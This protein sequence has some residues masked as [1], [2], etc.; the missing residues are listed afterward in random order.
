MEV[1]TVYGDNWEGVYID[2]VLC[3]ESQRLP[4]MAALHAVL[5]MGVS[6]P[7]WG[8]PDVKLNEI[9]LFTAATNRAGKFP[10]EIEKLNVTDRKE[11]TPY[12]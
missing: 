6:D 11:M 10:R 12:A 1:V 8:K 5:F 4:A 9:K 7:S 3:V 2:G